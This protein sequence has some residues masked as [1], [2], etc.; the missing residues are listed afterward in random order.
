MHIL[1]HGHMQATGHIPIEDAL[2][3]PCAAHLQP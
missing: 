2:D 1:H 3:L